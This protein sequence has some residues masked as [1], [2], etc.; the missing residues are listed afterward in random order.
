M[1]T[2]SVR[3]QWLSLVSLWCAAATSLVLLA[4]FAVGVADGSVSSFNGTLWLGLLAAAGGSLWG[5][6]TL[7]S[8]QHHLAAALVL[9]VVAVPGLLAALFALVLLIAQPRWN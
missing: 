7:R 9:S 2:P 3:G 6:W 4:F 5:G 8:R 1:T